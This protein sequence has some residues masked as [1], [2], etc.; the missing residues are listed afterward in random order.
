MSSIASPSL[1][2][3]KTFGDLKASGY[4][5]RPVKSEIRENLIASL[6][7]GENIFEGIY[8]YED[9]VIPEMQSQGQGRLDLLLVPLITSGVTTPRI[10]EAGI[11]YR[12]A[13]RVLDKTG[14][15]SETSSYAS[16][17]VR[18]IV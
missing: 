18:N 13:C 14:N 9:T 12:I 15:Y 11:N 2:L 1:T 6:H 16:I 10:S 7:K 5:S 3:P 17:L 4:V 8:G